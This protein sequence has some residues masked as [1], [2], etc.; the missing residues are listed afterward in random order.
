VAML[1]ERPDIVVS[2]M[3]SGTGTNSMLKTGVQWRCDWRRAAS[4]GRKK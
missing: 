2:L 4:I 1:Q 3:T